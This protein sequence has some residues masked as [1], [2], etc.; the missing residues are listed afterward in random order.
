M[1]HLG[2]LANPARGG[3]SPLPPPLPPPVLPAPVQLF[4]DAF[5]ELRP[6][7]PFPYEQLYAPDIVFEDPL[8]RTEGLPALRKHFQTLDKNLRSARF[9][10]SSTLVQGQEA[11]VFWT[12]TLELRRGPRR[13]VVVSGVSQLRFGDRLTYQRDHFDVGALIYEQ[14]PLLGSIIRW[15]KRHL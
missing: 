4:Q 7:R 14:V 3:P 9:D 2:M 6:D 5:R 1:D 11:A 12:M 15:L 13:P 10:Y 8:R